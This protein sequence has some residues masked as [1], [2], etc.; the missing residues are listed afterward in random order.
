MGVYW[1]FRQGGRGR[2]D[3][4]IFNSDP[5]EPRPPGKFNVL[6]PSKGLSF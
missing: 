1:C 4:L 6:S 3:I 5:P 2:E